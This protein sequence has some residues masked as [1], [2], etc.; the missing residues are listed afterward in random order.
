[1]KSSKQ[2][3]EKMVWEKQR[4]LNGFSIKIW[5]NTILKPSQ[6][7]AKQFS[8]DFSDC[9]T[10]TCFICITARVIQIISESKGPIMNI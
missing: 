3:L 7:K 6:Q 4:L 2:L 9:V 10:E 1:M 8:Y 5:G